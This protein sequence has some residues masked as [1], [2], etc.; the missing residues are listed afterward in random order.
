MNGR[1]KPS[2]AVRPLLQAYAAVEGVAA[3]A[4]SATRRKLTSAMRAIEQALAK[5]TVVG[6]PLKR[7]QMGGRMASDVPIDVAVT[8]AGDPFN[9]AH[10]PLSPQRSL[11]YNALKETPQPFSSGNQAP[12]ISTS[13]LPTSIKT[14]LLPDIG[15]TTGGARRRSAKKRAGT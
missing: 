2:P 14:Q 6:T 5:L 11:D 13:G 9:A 10:D 12:S 15:L 1:A 3:G 4:P 8:S 7:A